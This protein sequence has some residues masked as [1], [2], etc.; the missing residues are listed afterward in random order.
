MAGSIHL[1]H[2]R[3]RQGAVI[4]VRQVNLMTYIPEHHLVTLFPSLCI[5]SSE[6]TGPCWGTWTLNI[7]NRIPQLYLDGCD[8]QEGK[9]QA[10]K[11]QHMQLCL[12]F[13]FHYLLIFLALSFH[14]TAA[15]NFR[16]R[17]QR[18]TGERGCERAEGGVR[19]FCERSRE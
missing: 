4:P 5:C 15:G 1:L 2:H 9:P 16:R 14:F 8:N 10:G 7:K 18:G 19:V 11:G 17:G 13:L 3:K 12:N 6:G